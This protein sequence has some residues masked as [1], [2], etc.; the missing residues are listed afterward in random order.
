MPSD[1]HKFEFDSF[2]HSSVRNR[3]Y[4]SSRFPESVMIPAGLKNI[5]AGSAPH[6]QVEAFKKPDLVQRMIEAGKLIK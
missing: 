3:R 4:A 5:R 6:W 1:F 2:G